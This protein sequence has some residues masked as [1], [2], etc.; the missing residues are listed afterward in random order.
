MLDY[1]IYTFL[2][3]CKNMNYRV[4]AEKLNMT[5][6]AVTHHIK[7]LENEYGC[8]LFEY[9]NRILSKTTQ[10]KILESYALSAN[11]NVNNLKKE[12]SYSDLA[13]LRIGATKT[14]GQFL[15]SD[16][17]A[18]LFSIE[19]I[20]LTYFVDNTEVLL[21]K[22]RNGLLDFVFIEGFLN[23]DEFVS[24]TYKTDE[25]VGI[26]SKRHDFCE[27]SIQLEDILANRII[28]REEGSGTRQ[29]FE[30]ILTENNL[31]I[32][33]FKNK[34]ETNSFNTIIDLVSKNIG[35][36]FV[37]K[38]IA[39]ATENISSFRINDAS[40][41]HKFSCIHLKNIKT[42]ELLHHFISDD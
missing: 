24:F 1:K 29:A 34:V 7:Q 17:I 39:E 9:K 40:I 32:N 16:K 12:L 20:E 35:I 26:C 3:L 22:L 10:A 6:P 31:T 18:S 19:N 11:Y 41:H 27:R 33:S 2:E 4:T 13:K 14:I 23:S 37:Y 21:N 5:Q 36:S 30:L 38:S 28:L 8:V 15:L 25:L 42:P